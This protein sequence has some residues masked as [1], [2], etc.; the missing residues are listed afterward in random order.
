[1]IASIDIV[2]VLSWVLFGL[3]AGLITH[4]I[5]PADVSGGVVGTM[6]TGIIGALLGGFLAFSIFGVGI[7]GF[8]LQSF[9]IAVIGA[10]IF[11]AAERLIF[12][13]SEY[14]GIN[15]QYGFKGG[16]STRKPFEG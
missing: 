1:M 4:L 9:F 7:T 15:N 3:M 8:N 16:K 13:R 12:R 14:R 2:N 10:L 5:D 11:S 6:F